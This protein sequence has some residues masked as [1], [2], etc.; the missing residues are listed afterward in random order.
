MIKTGAVDSI[1]F[2]KVKRP[3]KIL[4]ISA[5]QGES[6]SDPLA[7]GTRRG[8]ACILTSTARGT[9]DRELILAWPETGMICDRLSPDCPHLL[10]KVSQDCATHCLSCQSE[11]MAG[12][13]GHCCKTARPHCLVRAA[14][15]FDAEMIQITRQ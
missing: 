6:Q 14:A 13:Y 8:K 11:S 9:L 2:D 10:R 3:V 12:Q 5:R 15:N 4:I 7:R 1:G